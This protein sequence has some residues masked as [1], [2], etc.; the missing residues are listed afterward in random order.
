[1]YE[2]LTYVYLLWVEV[3]RAREQQLLRALRA[4]PGFRNV[5][6]TEW[7]LTQTWFRA[8][9][10]TQDHILEAAIEVLLSIEG[11]AVEIQGAMHG[12]ILAVVFNTAPGRTTRP[13]RSRPQYDRALVDEPPP[14]AI[15]GWTEP[16]RVPPVPQATPAG[17]PEAPAAADDMRGEIVVA[18]GPPATE[19]PLAAVAQRYMD[20]P[21]PGRSPGAHAAISALYFMLAVLR[22]A[23]ADLATATVKGPPLALVTVLR[24]LG[25]LR[26]LL[27]IALFGVT[28][29]TRMLGGLLGRV[30]GAPP[31][32][33][34]GEEAEGGQQSDRAQA[35][36]PGRSADEPP[37]PT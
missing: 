29:V 3:T 21:P 36:V 18:E 9:L 4:A 1:M 16:I 8:A 24:A 35:G 27:P 25:Y 28:L 13:R 33:E 2:S 30:F 11:F 5:E 22:A 26:Y 14:L 17:Q 19:A 37:S 34:S 7:D 6:L 12:P 10:P 15:P 32:P 20:R 31:Q 23:L